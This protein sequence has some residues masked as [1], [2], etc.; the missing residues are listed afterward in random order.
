MY[1]FSNNLT[2]KK[3]YLSYLPYDLSEL[4]SR[5]DT[6]NLCEIRLRKLQPVV[7][8]Y[9]DGCVFLA[10]HGGITTDI[11]DAYVIGQK[12]LKQAVELILEFSI[13]A[14]QDSL[15]N[16]FV[17]IRGGH[18]IGIAGEVVDGTI[19]NFS[20]VTSLNYRIAKEH[21]GIAEPVADKI[22][23]DGKVKNT[24]IISPPMCGKTSLLRDL[25]RVVSKRG[26]K[27]GICDTRGEIAAVYDGVPSMDIG[28]ADVVSGA[29]KAFSMEM[30]LR[31]MAP[32]VIACD[33]LGNEADVTA[34]KKLFGCGVGI[35]ATAHKKDIDDL[36]KGAV[37]QIADEFECIVVLKNIGC[38]AEVLYV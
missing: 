14:H 22:M 34:C 6:E 27:V 15:K 5:C 37:A 32:E 13:Y 20:D 19:K 29:E 3:Q 12:E 36:K 10:K 4:V 9:V 23:T 35:I 7:L 25:I 26:V 1:V 21:I 16:G 11:R 18:R 8:S 33:E 31:C 24:L 17:T 38:D 28:Y 30:L 2:Q